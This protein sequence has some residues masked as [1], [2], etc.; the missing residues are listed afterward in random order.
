ML[1]S[2]TAHKLPSCQIEGNSL[3]RFGFTQFGGA[4][5]PVGPLNRPVQSDTDNDVVDH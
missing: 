2:V 3:L 1:R 5:F 4:V